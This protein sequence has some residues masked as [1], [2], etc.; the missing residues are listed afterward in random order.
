MTAE[1]IDPVNFGVLERDALPEKIASRLLSLIKERRLLSG[2]KLPPERD[3]A[4]TLQ[5]SRSSLREALRALAMI[6]VVDSRQGDG[7]YITSL[8]PELL[9]D[10]LEY[11]VA[12]ND[13]TF[14]HLFE[15]RK[16]LELSIVAV[17]AEKIT[18]DELVSLAE[19][20]HRSESALSD[21]R[22]FL[23]S[24]L[25]FHELIAAATH[26]PIF[27]SP[28]MASIRRLGRASRNRNAAI[29]G[30]PEQS[31]LDHQHILSALQKRDPNAAY[32]AMLD[33][34]NHVEVRLKSAPTPELTPTPT[35]SSGSRAKTQKARR[36]SR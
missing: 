20:L 2:H 30:L 23:Q 21:Y 17:A 8:E 6:G 5:V 33:H 34:M 22:V 1:F 18:D 11:V 7:T 36:A 35:T 4:A 32:Q 13:S 9:V 24:D 14:A 31:Y 28:Y 16:A 12:L 29:P 15:A 26:N 19:S 27:E 25:E 10:H 3:L